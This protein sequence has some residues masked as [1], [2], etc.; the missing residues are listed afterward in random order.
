VGLPTVVMVDPSGKERVRFTE[1][2]EPGK[3]VAAMKTVQ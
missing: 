2:I 3:M 1:Y